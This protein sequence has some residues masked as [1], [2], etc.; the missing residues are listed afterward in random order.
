MAHYFVS[1]AVV[2]CGF[3]YTRCLL[4]LTMGKARW[5]LQLCVTSFTTSLSVRSV[6]NIFMR[7]AQGKISLH[8]VFSVF[9]WGNLKVVYPCVAF[10]IHLRVHRTSSSGCGMHTT[11]LMRG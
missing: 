2:D 5:H 10:P 1:L 3:C 4:E 9:F 6:D 11:K 8:Y 7:C